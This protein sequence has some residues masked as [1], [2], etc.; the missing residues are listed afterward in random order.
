MLTR[1]FNYIGLLKLSCFFILAGNGVALLTGSS[2]LGHLFQNPSLIETV[3]GILLIAFGIPLLLPIGTL[4]KT[5]VHLLLLPSTILLFITS[6]ASFI[7]SGYVPEQLIEHGIK[8]LTPLFLL[9]QLALNFSNMNEIIISLKILIALTF[10]GHG[11]FALGAHY[12]PSGFIEMTTE[13]LGIPVSSS[14]LFL[15]IIGYIDILFALLIFTNFPIK[16]VYFYLIFWGLLTAIA[17]LVYGIMTNEGSMTEIIYWASNMVYRLPHGI[18]PLILFRL[19]R[20]K[21]QLSWG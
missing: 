19:Y 8:L 13:I 2:S 14:Y 11:L 4:K 9:R 10:I 3:F 7:H 5:K 1:S 15:K 18:I 17:R 21:G 6:Y 12:V 16:F 20:P